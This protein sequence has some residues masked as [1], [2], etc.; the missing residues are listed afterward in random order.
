MHEL[1]KSK[2]F[3][4]DVSGRISKFSNSKPK[5]LVYFDNRELRTDNWQLIKTKKPQENLELLKSWVADRVRTGDPR[6]HKP[7]L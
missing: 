5:F 3:I 2:Y 6:H 4:T 1:K 7:L